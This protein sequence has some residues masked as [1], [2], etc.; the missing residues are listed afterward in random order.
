[1]CKFQILFFH[2]FL[3]FEI[4][5]NV[6]KFKKLIFKMFKFQILFFRLFL[7]FEIKLN[8]LKF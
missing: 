7:N 4:K 5:L 3:N 6:F 8:V 1:M 2:F